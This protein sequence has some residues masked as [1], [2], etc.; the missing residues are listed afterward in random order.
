MA[1]RLIN[2]LP[3]AEVH[4]GEPLPPVMFSDIAAL[5]PQPARRRKSGG[6]TAFIVATVGVHVVAA[7]A[8]ISA[9]HEIRGLIEPTPIVASL[10]EAPTSEEAPPEYTPPVQAV[11][12]ALPV[13]QELSF[14]SD[15]VSVAP[16]ATTTAITNPAPQAVA[17]PVID[18]VDYLRV[19]R[20]V[21][22]KESQR[23][24]EHGTV[25]LR[26]LIDAMGRPAQIQVE[27]SSGYE[28]LDAAGRDAIA[29]SLFR[30][31][32]VNGVAQPAQVL[33]PIEF[34]PRAT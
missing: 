5:R 3:D 20:P 8:L 18:D 23:R 30:P 6:R 4:R 12:Y 25:I 32:E 26:V 24:R 9:R 34:A 10:I 2:D 15:A 13:P 19:A 7:A 28:R 17:P 27:R 31:H 14:E 22:P 21:Y 11:A 1:A 33:I 16:V 29:K